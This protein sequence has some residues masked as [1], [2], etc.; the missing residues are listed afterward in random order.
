MTSVINEQPDFAVASANEILAY[1]DKRAR[2]GDPDSRFA[3]EA[4]VLSAAVE[5]L[6]RHRDMQA[7]EIRRLQ[8]ELDE[9][10]GDAWEREQERQMERGYP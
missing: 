4:G 3:R 8:R 2:Q 7:R 1:A 5:I 10:N 9:I 6:C